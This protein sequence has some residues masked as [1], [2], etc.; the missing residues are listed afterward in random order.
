[1][2]KWPTVRM[3]LG[4]GKRCLNGWTRWRLIM[5]T[6]ICGL[7]NR[8]S[9]WQIWLTP[10]TIVLGMLVRCT[11]VTCNRNAWLRSIVKRNRVVW[12]TVMA[13]ESLPL[14][15]QVITNP[16]WASLLRLLVV[17]AS[18]LFSAVIVWCLLV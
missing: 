7:L 3:L 15:L 11:P 12:S 17:L 1:M 14:L 18:C 4:N 16:Q 10:V 9:V 8:R 13:Q 2:L 6:L 5:S